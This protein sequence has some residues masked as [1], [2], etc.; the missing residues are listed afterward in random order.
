V[1]Y[2]EQPD[3]LIQLLKDVGDGLQKDPRFSPFILE[4]IE[5][6]GID[7]FAEWSMQLKLRIKTVPLKQWEVG[8]EL[9]KRIRIAFETA[10]VRVPFPAIA[11]AAA[12]ARE[13]P[14]P[15]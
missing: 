11:A 5:V 6:Y 3:R 8:R 4:P 12:E 2:N 15:Q 13:R 14:Q 9:R 10:G 7:G 1:P